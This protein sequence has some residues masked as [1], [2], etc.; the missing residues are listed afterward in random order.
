VLGVGKEMNILKNYLLTAQQ[1]A[2]QE[3]FS[4]MELPITPI[5]CVGI[6]YLV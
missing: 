4:S 3:V 6:P 1:A 2:F 5:T